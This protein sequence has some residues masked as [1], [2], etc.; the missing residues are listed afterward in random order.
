MDYTL[1]FAAHAPR[2]RKCYSI[3]AWLRFNKAAR[4]ILHALH[5]STHI[6]DDSQREKYVTATTELA[7]TLSRLVENAKKRFSQMSPG[8]SQFA[9]MVSKW[10]KDMA[11]PI[12]SAYWKWLNALGITT[13]QEMEEIQNSFGDDKDVIKCTEELHAA[14]AGFRGVAAQLNT[15]LQKGENKV[16]SY[17]N[18]KYYSYFALQCEKYEKQ[19]SCGD[20]WL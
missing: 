9:M 1:L 6:M 4:L 15:A 20:N 3:K 14:E 11:D 10:M 18:T 7:E 2:A 13:R 5:H 17:I 12:W 8:S 16:T 19:A